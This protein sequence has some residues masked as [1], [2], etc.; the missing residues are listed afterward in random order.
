MSTMIADALIW[1]L[2]G[3]LWGVAGGL[4]ISFLSRDGIWPEIW[5]GIIL[6]AVFAGAVVGVAA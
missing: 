5:A 6:L 4:L 3:L 1:A 2:A